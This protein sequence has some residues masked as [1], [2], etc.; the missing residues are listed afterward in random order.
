[1]S[2]I[3]WEADLMPSAPVKE[4]IH[5]AIKKYAKLLYI[6]S[7]EE[8]PLRTYPQRKITTE[9]RIAKDINEAAVLPL[10]WLLAKKDSL[11]IRR[12]IFILMNCES[13]IITQNNEVR[14]GLWLL[15]T[16]H[17]VLHFSHELCK[18]V[19]TFLAFPTT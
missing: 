11:N 9:I 1:M 19:F 5:S 16:A 12:K 8:F 13:G 4:L 18:V 15:L 17:M 14:K 3:N 10:N 2:L 7:W 6:C